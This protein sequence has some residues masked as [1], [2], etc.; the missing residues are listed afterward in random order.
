MVV[1]FLKAFYHNIFYCAIFVEAPPLSHYLVG[2]GWG[3]GPFSIIPSFL[4]C[5]E[6]YKSNCLVF[7]I[8]IVYSTISYVVYLQ[9]VTNPYPKNYFRISFFRTIQD[10]LCV[11]FFTLDE[12]PRLHCTHIV[13]VYFQLYLYIR[14]FFIFL[15]W[16]SH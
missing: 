6:P 1:P 16:C 11:I 10:R 12:F 2:W 4:L 5:T 9:D 7:V 8:L 15:Y 3:W 14:I 13:S